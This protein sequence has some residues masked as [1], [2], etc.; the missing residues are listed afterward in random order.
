MREFSPTHTTIIIT[1]TGAEVV[2]GVLSIQG[3]NDYLVD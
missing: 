1:Q 2:E 3:V